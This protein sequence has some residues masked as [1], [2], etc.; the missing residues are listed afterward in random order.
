MCPAERV[1]TQAGAGAWQSGTH[2]HFPPAISVSLVVSAAARPCHANRSLW[3]GPCTLPAPVTVLGAHCRLYVPTVPAPSQPGR[4]FSISSSSACSTRPFPSHRPSHPQHTGTIPAALRP[5][6]CSGLS[7][8][9]L[10]L[11]LHFL[12]L[13][14]P[15]RI[16]V[17]FC[18]DW[19]I[20]AICFRRCRTQTATN[21]KSSRETRPSPLKLCGKPMST[22]V[23]G[24]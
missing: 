3:P 24:S 8:P 20:G 14:R 6:V 2:L 22:A 23:L 7:R 12:V 21:F 5:R 19:S 13:F 10:S 4:I 11:F 1:K 17:S 16:V 18:F 15:K 9:L